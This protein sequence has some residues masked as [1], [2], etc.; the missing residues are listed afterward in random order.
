MNPNDPPPSTAA[1]HNGSGQLHGGERTPESSC[2]N[3]NGTGEEET[4]DLKSWDSGFLNG[5]CCPAGEHR[6][7]SKRPNGS[8]GAYDES[9]PTMVVKR[10]RIDSQ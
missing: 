8:D 5:L 3:G 4:K 6:P 7:P 2:R 9:C 1:P 10:S